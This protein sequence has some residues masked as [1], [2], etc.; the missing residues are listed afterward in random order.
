MYKIENRTMVAINDGANET[1]ISAHNWHIAQEIV[2]LTDI[3]CNRYGTNGFPKIRCIKLYRMI[4][5]CDLRE[6]KVAI[7]AA[8]QQR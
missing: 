6:A 7:E 5:N 1:V 2:G 4:T 8:D 3:D